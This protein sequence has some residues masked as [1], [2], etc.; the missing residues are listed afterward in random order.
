[1]ANFVKNQSQTIDPMLPMSEPNNMESV[2]LFGIWKDQ[3]ATNSVEDSMRSLRQCRLKK[4]F[5]KR[6]L[7]NLNNLNG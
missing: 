4:L 5:K 6:K 3:V 1:M 7:F 2:E